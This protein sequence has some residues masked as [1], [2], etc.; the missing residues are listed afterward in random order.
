MKENLYDTLG[1]PK[2]ASQ[3]DIK[4]AF[5]NKAKENHTDKQG[6]DHNK[7]V[8]INHAHKILSDKEKR[9]RYDTTGQDSNEQSFETKFIQLVNEVF[10]SIIEDTERIENVDIVKSF[11]S[12]L[13]NILANFKESQRINI[14]RK[15]KYQ[16]VKKRLKCKGNNVLVTAVDNQ[17]N[18]CD[19]TLA[20]L[21]ANIDFI[22]KAKEIL[23]L[24]F[25]DFEKIIST[26]PTSFITPP[27]PIN[28]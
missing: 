13:N 7:M 20:G 9:E 18:S 19:Q 22:Y 27:F 11:N 5:R 15:E 17:I 23:K 21:N 8:A 10:I 28:L 2:D 24:Y 1:V 12:Q 4:T 6:G 16:K 26:E 3:K 25:Y 14:F